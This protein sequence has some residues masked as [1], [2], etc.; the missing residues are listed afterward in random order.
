MAIFKMDKTKQREIRNAVI[1]GVSASASTTIWDAVQARV[2]ALS[3][4]NTE[5]FKALGGAVLLGVAPRRNGL[6]KDLVE[7]IGLGMI[8]SGTLNFAA[9]PVSNLLSNIPGL[10]GYAPRQ[11]AAPALGAYSRSSVSSGSLSAD[12]A[13][14]I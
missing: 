10:S 13:P 3:G 12:T 14:V 2:P 11:L 7:N 1:V 9:Q 4:E 6:A 5:L 8:V